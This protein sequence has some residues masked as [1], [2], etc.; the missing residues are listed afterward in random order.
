VTADQGGS[1]FVNL[2]GTFRSE[3]DGGEKTQKLATKLYND[4]FKG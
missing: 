3:S 4:V 1:V 2:N